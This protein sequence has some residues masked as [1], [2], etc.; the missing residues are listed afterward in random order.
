MRE[1]GIS[2]RFAAAITQRT[3]KELIDI[4]QSIDHDQIDQLMGNLFESAEQM[5]A[6]AN[7]LDVAY[8]RLLSLSCAN[9]AAGGEFKGASRAAVWAA[10]ILEGLPLPPAGRDTTARLSSRRRTESLHACPW[11]TMLGC[12]CGSPAA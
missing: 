7:M 10:M 2:A 11:S 12:Q 8:M 1:L 6:M 3:K 4:H 5:K 9:L